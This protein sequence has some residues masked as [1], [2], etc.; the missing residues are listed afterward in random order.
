MVGSR[1][2]WGPS[3]LYSKDGSLSAELQS[4]VSDAALKQHQAL[5]YARSFYSYVSGDYADWSGVE[6]SADATVH[7][8]VQASALFHHELRQRV[9]DLG[10]AS[11]S[12]PI[13][14]ELDSTLRVGAGSGAPFLPVTLLSADVHGQLTRVRLF[15]YSVGLGA[16]WW[17]AG[18]R[19]LFLSASGSLWIAGDTQLEL[20]PYLSWLD[21]RT[22]SGRVNVGTS[23]GVLRGVRGRAMVDL[24][25]NVGNV[26]KYVERPLIEKAPSRLA[27]DGTVS[28]R[29]WIGDNYGYTA[30]L[31]G[32]GQL[33]TFAR[34]G[35]DCAVFVEL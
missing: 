26:P 6:F 23:F 20:K 3:E 4:T 16:S 34:A 2:E 21:S 35:V 31:G 7:N 28:A 10:L 8:E 18:R 27:I 19:E 30:T 33:G 24:R 9:G 29:Y 1:H 25:L 13:V 15:Q 12:F 32:G 11:L 14:N 22:T 5:V 17:S